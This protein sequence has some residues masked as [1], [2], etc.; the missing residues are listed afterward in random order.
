MQAFGL[1]LEPRVWDLLRGHGPGLQVRT[2]HLQCNV[3]ACSS[4]A[5]R[6]LADVGQM[7]VGC[8][9]FSVDRP[10]ES[11][12]GNS[13][14]LYWQ[15]NSLIGINCLPVRVVHCHSYTTKHFLTNVSISLLF[16]KLQALGFINQT[17]WIR[18]TVFNC[19]LQEN[20]L[21]L[22]QHINFSTVE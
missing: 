22:K 1:G 13:H 14:K 21:N 11:I 12:W 7:Q 15:N 8:F 6:L 10:S 5:L 18:R 20:T 9:F 3:T 16:S 19:I 17:C 4:C 2:Q